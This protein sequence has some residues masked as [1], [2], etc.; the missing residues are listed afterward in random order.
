[1]PYGYVIAQVTISSP[2]DYPP[3]QALAAAA[4]AK[5]GGEYIVRGGQSQ[6]VEGNPP[7]ER[8]VII[9]F[10]SYEQALAWY[11]SD[12]YAEAMPLRWKA[13]DA[14]MTIVEGV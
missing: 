12:E 13:A 8:T 2:D 14:I 10:P 7:A 4:I 1:M 9:R 3:Y 6:T 5:F 11:N